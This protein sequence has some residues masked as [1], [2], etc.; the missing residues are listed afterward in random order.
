MGPRRL[1]PAVTAPAFLLVGAF[2]VPM[3]CQAA[4]GPGYSLKWGASGVTVATTEWFKWSVRA[5]PDGQ[6]GAIMAWEENRFRRMCCRDTRDVYAQ[7]VDASGKLLWGASDL[8]VAGE[9]EGEETAGML[10]SPGGGALL[11]WRRGMNVLMAREMD[12]GGATMREAVVLGN[13]P[14]GEWGGFNGFAA[15]PDGRAGVLVWASEFPGHWQVRALPVRRAEDRWGLGPPVTLA[16][17]TSVRSPSITALADGWLVLWADSDGKGGALWGVWLDA[18]GIQSG[19]PFKVASVPR[20]YVFMSTAPG[21]PGRAWVAFAASSPDD[22]ARKLEVRLALVTRGRSGA[23][24]KSAAAGSVTR[25]IMF[26]PPPIATIGDGSP[27]QVMV[28]EMVAWRRTMVL[29]PEAGG[30]CLLL[31]LDGERLAVRGALARG[32]LRLGPETEV[33]AEASPSMAPEIVADPLGGWIVAWT[34]QGGNVA[35]IRVA[36]LERS[37]GKLVAGPAFQPLADLGLGTRFAD[38]LPLGGGNVLMT[39]ISAIPGGAG[40]LNLQMLGRASGKSS[41]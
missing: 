39:T 24:I 5:V 40:L 14:A 25:V 12:P 9:E 41:R 17:G 23:A 2:L 29:A 10:A 26:V 33:S 4:A 19:K 8:K 31:K 6:G 13:E 34:G 18:T 3:P 32:E 27:A 7:R 35:S 37:A 36:R 28:R 20:P 16:M 38:L 22:P 30:G 21:G 1:F 11:L 15:S